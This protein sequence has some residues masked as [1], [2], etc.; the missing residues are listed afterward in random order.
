MD[1]F[2][3]LVVGAG[4]S[5]AVSAERLATRAKRVLV[6]ERRDHIAGNCYDF[7]NEHGIRVSK[8]GA[9]LFHTDDERVWA[10]VSRFAEW[11]RW[12]HQVVA[13][14]EGKLVPVPVNITTVNRL[15]NQHIR[16]EA[17]MREWLEREHEGLVPRPPRDG[18]EAAIARVGP[19]LYHQIFHTYTWKQWGKHPEQL[20]ASVLERIPV[21]DN[22]DPRYFSDRYQALPRH[23][24]TQ[25]VQRILAHPRI[26]VCVGVDFFELLHSDRAVFPGL[27]SEAV[28][29]VRRR[30]QQHQLAVV[31]TGPIDRYFRQAGYPRLEYRSIQFTTQHLRLSGYYQPNSV[32]N[33]PGPEV[34]FTRIVEYKHFLQQRSDY[35]TIV[36]EVSS[37]EGDPY[38]PVPNQRNRD[39]YR[40]YQ[41]LAERE[42]HVHFI[43]R[44]AS[45]KYFNMD[46]A[47]ANALQYWDNHEV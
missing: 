43:G 2:D 27:P 19:R 30:W 40:K 45:Y 3:V 47:I 8:Y 14:V 7:V 37:D 31:Y 32:V 12:E 35:T 21:R 20:D 41:Q 5:G 6:V 18:R 22:W 24:Y 46:Q 29:N 13:Y 16:S 36:S 11:E 1:S 10:Y 23:G 44:L 39:L 9:H 26:A 15:F 38:Y 28:Q 25:M 4:L 42:Q 17:E 33:Y 34:P